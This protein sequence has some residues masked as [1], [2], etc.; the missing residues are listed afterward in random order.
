MRQRMK[1][2]AAFWIALTLVACL[3]GYAAGASYQFSAS[4]K[5]NF[6]KMAGAASAAMKEQLTSQYNKLQ[7]HYKQELEWEHKIKT[8]HANNEG[9]EKK[10]RN[11][12]QMLD[13][14]RIKQLESDIAKLK[15]RYEPVIKVYDTQRN[16]LN[17]IK[18]VKTS[19]KELIKVMNVSVSIS[20]A[21]ADHAK[22]EIRRQE[23]NLK[24]ARSA[25]NEK[26]KELRSMLAEGASLTSKIKIAKSAIQASNKLYTAEG[27]LLSQAVRQQAAGAALQSMRKMNEQAQAINK[28]KSSIY[29]LE[30][31]YSQLLTKVQLRIR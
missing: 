17:M 31:Q 6:D 5:A 13:N 8:I 26:K 27:K 7:E 15:K 24:A 28:Q 10:I 21:A 20:K 2:L 11:Q 1:Q 14:D 30:Q 22:A 16:Q 4:A 19:N 29:T 25:A 9:L 18:A 23:A 12:I 3:P